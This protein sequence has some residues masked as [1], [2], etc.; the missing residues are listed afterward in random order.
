M[1]SEIEVKTGRLID[2]LEREG[3][4]GVLLNGQH[5]F[6]WITGG[7]SNGVDQSR[8]NGV[9]SILIT[10][11]GEKFLLA[12]RIEMPRMLAEEVSDEDFEPVDYAWQDEKSSGRWLIDLAKDLAGGDVVTD[13]VLDPATPAIDG[14]IS[15]VRRSLTEPEIGRFKSLG[16]DASTALDDVF[17]KIE[18]G[19][20]ELEIA[21][22]MRSELDRY[23]IR[24]VVALVAA[25]DRIAKYRHP[26][27]TENRFEN[28]VMLV[29]CARRHGLIV[30]LTRIA[31]IGAAQSELLERTESTAFVN[32]TLWNA[33]KEGV[34]GRELY[35]AAA[36][37]YAD[38]GFADEIDKHHQGGAAG[39]RTREWVA[40]P[41]SSDTV[42]PD[43]AF[44]WNP[45]ITGT[46]VEETVI[47]SGGRCDVITASHKFPQIVTTIDGVEYRSPGILEI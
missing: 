30:S 20:T 47:V 42:G 3:M 19:Q 46:K 45:S 33:T 31:T 39:Y 12:N 41:N 13:I 11:S 10:R 7:A 35:D 28:T 2:F 4:A 1:S 27:P 44:A 34:S 29:S 32:A 26:V 6:A 24:S 18:P 22:L 37:A 14:S 43:Q 38:A 8:D 36:K 40:H 5:N 9:A 25:N 15:Q 23:N 16:R 21:S 17:D